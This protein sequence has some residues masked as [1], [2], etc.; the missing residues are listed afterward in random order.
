MS[1]QT[2][3][4]KNPTI[5]EI[6]KER[7]DRRKLLGGLFKTIPAAALMTSQADAKETSEAQ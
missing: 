7:F 4:P 1:S 2:N 3:Q 6:M 5:G